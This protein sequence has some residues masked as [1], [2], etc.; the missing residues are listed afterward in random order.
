MTVIAIW[1]AA[2]IG[3]AAAV[4][5]ASTL[6]RRPRA[7]SVV[8]TGVFVVVCA[9]VSMMVALG[10][11]LR[12]A[13]GVLLVV[14]TGFAV[15][16]AASDALT[17]T[18]PPVANWAAAAGV[19]VTVAADATTA[20]GPGLGLTITALCAGAAWGTL[21]EVVSR[22]KPDAVGG[23]DARAGLWIVAVVVWWLG[24][25][26]ALALIAVTHLAGA[27]SGLI[28]RRRQVPF[29]PWLA[30]CVVIAPVLHTAPGVG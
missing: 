27:L 8:L 2:M 10:D 17:W 18:I 30:G 29:G 4:R 25:T 11:E 26:P 14:V 28:T 3:G 1:V 7:G 13:Q 16:A 15:F 23:G 21:M 22:I 5:Y 24:I 9:A 19:G 12:W 20:D 6:D